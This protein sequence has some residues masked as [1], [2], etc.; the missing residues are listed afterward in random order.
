MDDRLYLRQLR[1]G[2][3]FGRQ[4]PVAAQ[5]ANFI[6]LVGDRVTRE[7]VIIDPAWDVRGVLDRAAEDDM[8]VVGAMV[9]HYHPDHCGGS[10]FGFTVQGLPELLAL[11]PC[12]VHVHEA[13]AHG[14]RTV[15]KL[16][17]T[18][19]TSHSSGDKVKV[20]E[21]EIECLHTPGHTPGSQC[22]R[23]KGALIAGDTLFLQGCGRVDL[24]GGNAEEMRRTLT[25]R[26]ATLPGDLVLYPGHS[27]GEETYTTP[28][29]ASLTDVR[30]R[31]QALGWF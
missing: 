30:R 14:V 26:L 8:K 16:S 28:G 17:A 27:Y 3:D 19:L 25:Q 7:C 6:Y 13:E 24:P 4:N 12:P 31:N 18:D 10:M 29:S 20:G 11:N 1:A 9:T 22:F 23:C 15:T 5:M 2:R 21:V